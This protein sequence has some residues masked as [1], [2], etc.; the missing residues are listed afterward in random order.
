MRS[1]LL[2][3]F[4]LVRE[5]YQTSN[6]IQNHIEELIALQI[7]GFQ[8][9][10]ICYSIEVSSFVCEIPA[11]TFLNVITG[12]TDILGVSD[13]TRKTFTAWCIVALHSPN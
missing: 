5:T 10:E 8:F 1:H 2:S 7:K 6:I 12:H 3:A 4:L 13:T 11:R 9:K